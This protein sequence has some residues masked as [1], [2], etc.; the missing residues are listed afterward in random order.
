MKLDIKKLN[1]G[2]RS[3]P[4][5]HAEKLM[6]E[7]APIL[8]S[9]PAMCWKDPYD[10]VVDV[11]VHMLMPG[12]WPC[13]PNWHTDF[14]PRDGEGNKLPELRDKKHL[15]WLW[16]SGPPYTEF[17]DG[18]EITPM[19]WIP[20]TQ[21]DEHR[22]TQSEEHCWRM[23]IRLA[24]AEIAPRVTDGDYLRRHTQVYLDSDNFTW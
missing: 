11:K 17:R 12:Q 16:L 23:F 2:L 6:P 24:P 10:Y 19:T 7:I 4:L 13:I 1:C 22:G 15:M 8:W 20:F 3:A 5:A 9:A 21:F 18:R 14:C